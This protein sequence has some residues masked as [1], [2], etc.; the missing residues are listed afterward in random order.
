MTAVVV[1]GVWVLCVWALL[2]LARGTD[3]GLGVLGVLGDYSPV[4]EAERILK[5]AK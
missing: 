2:R 1:A 4:I 5:G 3:C